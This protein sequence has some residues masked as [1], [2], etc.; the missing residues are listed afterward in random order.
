MNGRF[1]SILRRRNGRSAAGPESARTERIER[2]RP[3]DRARENVSRARTKARALWGDLRHR[4]RRVWVGKHRVHV[5]L[6]DVR[7]PM[8]EALARA[9]RQRLEEMPGVVWARVHWP[10]GRAIVSREPSVDPKAIVDRVAQIE[11]ELACAAFPFSDGIEHP[12]DDEPLRRARAEL[13]IDAAGALS[14]LALRFSAVK[15]FPFEFDLAAIVA[16][17]EGIPQARGFLD[18]KVGRETVDLL[19]NLSSSFS[20]ALVQGPTGPA[21]DALS[22][23]LRARELL[24]RRRV[25]EEREE[26]LFGLPERA[27]AS[28]KL[29]IAPRP[30]L[31]GGPIEQYTDKAVFAS[32]AGVGLGLAASRSFAGA[33][34]PIFG[35]V[36]KPARLGREAFAAH[37]G[38]RLAAR[39]VLVIDPGALRLLDR[40]DTVVV[41]GDVLAPGPGGMRSPE[42]D[43]LLGAIKKARL[44]HYVA[45]VRAET[46]AWSPE[47]PAIDLDDIAGAIRHLQIEGH[48][49]LL[50]AGHASPGFAA[51]DVGVG[52]V[53]GEP[54]WGAHVL[55][56]SSLAEA[57][58]VV[59]GVAAARAA[60]TQGVQMSV[61][62]AATGLVLSVGGLGDR[63]VRRV[64]T[65]S[66]AA[67]VLAMAN[68]VRLAE[69]VKG[70]PVGGPGDVTPWHTLSVEQSL[71]AL[72]SRLE[73]LD[74]AEALERRVD[75]IEP[76]SN[77]RVFGQMLVEELEN[78]LTPVLVA[79]A[80][81][82]A[83]TGA[84]TDAAM[85]AGV[86][87]VNALIG[88]TQRYRIEKELSALDGRE[89]RAAR[90]IRAGRSREIA[91]EELV[92]GD[93][94][95]LHSG[96]AVPADARI[97]EAH[98]LEIDESSL[99]GESLPVHKTTSA[100]SAAAI[101]E[102]RSMVYEGTTIAA[103]RARAVVTAIGD[104]TE[105]RRAIAGTSEAGPT[106]VE[107]RL[108]SLT[109]L[110]A[111]I[112]AAA[113]IAVI[114]AG[115]AKGQPAQDVIGA[116]VSL[117]VAAVPEGLPILAT[118]AQLAAA[119]R[120]ATRGALVRNPRAIEALG[121]VNVVCA[122]KTGT[123]TVGRI[124]LRVVSTAGIERPID[125][126][127][128]A[129]RAVLGVALRGG[130]NLARPLPHLTDRAIADGA[131]A[132]SVG[133]TEGVGSWE[134]IHELP[135][136]PAR[137]Y[138]AV[139]G[140][141]PGGLAIAVKGA[142][143]VI[144]SRCTRL[145][146][147]GDVVELDHQGRE[148]LVARSI[149]LAAKGLRVLAV[150]ERPAH[151]ENDKVR[152]PRVAELVFR[153]F[154]GLA[155]PVRP[156]ARRAI[157]DLD[158]AGV[159]VVMITGDHPSTAAAIAKELGLDGD[160]RV[161][162]GPEMNGMS[163]TE[164]EGALPHVSVFARVTPA[165]KVRLV[166]TLQRQGKVVAMTG[167]GANDAPAI[168][169]ADVGIALGERSTAAARRAADMVVTDERIETIV[170]A[171]L[172]GRALWTSVRDAVALLVGGNLGEIGFT[173]A[174]SIFSGRSPL[175]ARQLLLVNILTDTAPALAVALR[176]PSSV[177]PAK[178]LEEGPEAS[179]GRALE[180]E[181]AMHAVVTTVATTGAWLAARVLGDRAGADTVALLTIVGTQLA[182][183]IVRGGASIPVIAASAGAGALL[184]GIVETPGL[185]TFFGSRPLGPVG[186][187]IAAAA[188]GVATVATLAERPLV[189]LIDKRRPRE[190]NASLF[191]RLRAVVSRQTRATPP[192]SESSAEHEPSFSYA[193]GLRP[194][195][196]RRWRWW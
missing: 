171:V 13:G 160:S 31:A 89:T 145:Q 28:A 93:V 161:V 148:R 21:V 22:R 16:A 38:A 75:P 150:A 131:K 184:V 155:D 137:G 165:Q 33:A 42:I 96:D 118:I 88:A 6:R 37:L 178:L 127:D 64:M 128:D 103:G 121:R 101:A 141:H 181:I 166:K 98:H 40:I 147:D 9:I 177:D 62:E 87:G 20:S 140:R 180:R 43:A 3:L 176:P 162:T 69:G 46:P 45:T 92:H 109:A 195:S 5:E 11:R 102:R 122:D 116:G 187:G 55:C 153:G 112:A 83:L 8:R 39:G 142:P 57:R 65:A 41:A 71:A 32:L 58:M 48:A 104:E 136:E 44:T 84:V 14:A 182:Q 50:I 196:D 130:P 146:D 134:R 95:E 126:L 91:P 15:V 34:A 54:A 159:R 25:F 107:A 24:A 125:E 2:P 144:L 168:R 185:S 49:V 77:A 190:S 193:R 106:G 10:L 74:E 26:D 170:H 63:T 192:A 129:R 191:S 82:S 189:E 111:P 138:H 36:P 7:G 135:F 59:E 94:I 76:P 114:G 105:A 27:S 79:G 151:E 149:E 47:T 29:E 152:D 4:R 66:N 133:V 123:L 97:V 61:I 174:G 51:A 35:G 67:A 60:S 78:P 186:L 183:T 1:A 108:E 154:L 81:L 119:K 143:E 120:L 99:T 80:G 73:G 86:L 179:L 56:G 173:V 23:G 115:I 90:V 72:G 188:T 132:A 113:G 163:D 100:T 19:L 194:R 70:A 110:T 18:R 68:A 139:L 52:L 12:A 169:L 30:A 157:A 172:E 85:I 124:E 53:N 158:L 167:D 156:S 175:N 17:L 117:A 164:L